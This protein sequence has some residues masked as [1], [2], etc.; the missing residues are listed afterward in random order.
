MTCLAQ[1]R[2]Q[3]HGLV[4]EDFHLLVDFCIRKEK[5]TRKTKLEPVNVKDDLETALVKT[6]QESQVATVNDT[7]LYTV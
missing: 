5:K 1:L 7:R 2:F 6:F 4:A 3:Q